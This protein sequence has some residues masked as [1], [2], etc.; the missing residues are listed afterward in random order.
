MMKGK[1]SQNLKFWIK[2]EIKLHIGKK[3]ICGS[4]QTILLYIVEEL[5]GGGSV[6]VAVGVSDM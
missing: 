2:D 5:A 1:W 6:T 4:S 3:I